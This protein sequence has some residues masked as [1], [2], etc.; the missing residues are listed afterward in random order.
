MVG[1]IQC[2]IVC[3]AEIGGSTKT[4]QTQLAKTA[5]EVDFALTLKGQGAVAAGT[6]AGIGFE[7][8]FEL[9]AGLEATAQVFAAHKAKARVVVEEPGQAA[10][11]N[12]LMFDRG[13]EAAVDLN[14]ALCQSGGSSGGGQSSEEDTRHSCCFDW[15]VATSLRSLL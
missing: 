15:H 3:N 1:L 9:E 14:A 5:R 6:G 8:G 11:S 13:I 10:A 2:T 12:L 7:A 4:A